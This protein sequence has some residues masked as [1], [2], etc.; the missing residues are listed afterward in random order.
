MSENRISLEYEA[1]RTG[2]AIG[3]IAPRA[4]LAVSGRDRA[5]YLQGLLTNDIQAL[6]PGTGCYAAWLTPQG[7]MIT[8]LHV[9]ESGDM[10]LLD[11]PAELGDATL[12]RL[13]QF[14]F[15]EDVQLGSLAAALRA[16]WLHGPAAPDILDRVLSDSPGVAAWAEYANARL[17]FAGAPV[18]VARISQL[19]VPGYVAYLAPDQ[20]PAFIT[21]LRAAG[22]IDAGADAIEA[23]RVEA[24]Y[25]VFGIDMT[26]DTI[27]LEAQIEDRA[28]SFTKG[29]YVGQEVVIRVLHR[30][31]GRVARKLVGLRVDGN[32]PARGA[33]LLSG[34]RD[35]GFVTSAA[36]SPHLGAVALGYV[37]RDFVEPG[38][39]VA[40][41]TAAGS[42]PAV[43][44]TRPMPSA[45]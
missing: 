8:D 3:E 9:L 4:Q 25:P 31:G 16:V 13:D 27:P 37:H 44:T 24:G 15:S 36:A 34:T 11:V 17:T 18:V 20:A 2:A 10:I 7:R 30:G 21:A 41:Q 45:V 19:G 43:V 29:C 28:V 40:V 35:I 38:T 1:V 12:Q 33:R 6:T 14:L 42:E 5:A 22:A 32:V 39:A 23:A 26:D